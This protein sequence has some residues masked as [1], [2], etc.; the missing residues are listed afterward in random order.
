MSVSSTSMG[1]ARDAQKRISGVGYALDGKT[2]L[3]ERLR[4]PLADEELVFDEQDAN[5]I[6]VRCI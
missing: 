2:L 4:D 5:P 3:S 1:R 6:S